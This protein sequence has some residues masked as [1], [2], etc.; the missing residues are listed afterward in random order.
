[1]AGKLCYWQSCK[2]RGVLNPDTRHRNSRFGKNDYQYG[3]G[4]KHHASTESEQRYR[5]K[6][7]MPDRIYT[8]LP[9]LSLQINKAHENQLCVQLI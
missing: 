4:H 6:L 5:E 2:R 9:L 7:R 3:A 8:V 1:V